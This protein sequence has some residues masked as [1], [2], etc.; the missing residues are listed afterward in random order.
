M[1]YCRKAENFYLNL[2]RTIPIDFRKGEFF[3][4]IGISY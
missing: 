4:S 3:N 2:S 1:F